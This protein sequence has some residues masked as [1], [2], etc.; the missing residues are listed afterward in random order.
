[1]SAFTPMKNHTV[2]PY[3]V[4]VS[5]KWE[6]LGNIRMS[7]LGQSVTAVQNVARA[8]PQRHCLKATCVFTQER[9][10]IVAVIVVRLT[11]LKLVSK[12][13]CAPIQ[14][15]GFSTAPNVAKVLVI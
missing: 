1:M 13:T 2:A 4:L 10:H 9:G 7:T 6:L 5:L 12:T 14:E 15:K 3:V 8:T 11:D